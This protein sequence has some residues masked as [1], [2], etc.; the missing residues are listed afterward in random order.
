M[1]KIRPIFL[2]YFGCSGLC[3]ILGISDIYNTSS[4]AMA[5]FT[6]QIINAVALIYYFYWFDVRETLK[7]HV[8][9]SESKLN[10]HDIQMILTKMLTEEIKDESLVDLNKLKERLSYH[11]KEHERW[12][13]DLEENERKLH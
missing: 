8:K 12:K 5:T 7:E 4:L 10:Q 2:F 3:L 11:S 9:R 1:E 6:W 13:D